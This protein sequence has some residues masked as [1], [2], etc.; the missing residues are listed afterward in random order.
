MSETQHLPRRNK[1][2]V[3]QSGKSVVRAMREDYGLSIIQAAAA[4]T[5]TS[6]NIEIWEANPA[7]GPGENFLRTQFENFVRENGARAVSNMLFS[8]YPLKLAREI[9]GVGIEDIAYEFGGYSK[10]A[11]QKFESNDRMLDRKILLQIE[12]KVRKHFSDACQVSLG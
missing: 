10:S 11:W 5:T 4:L 6:N 3:P 8:V 12:D 1:T 2:P 7:M 9:L